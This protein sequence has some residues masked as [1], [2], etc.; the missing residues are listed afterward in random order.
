MSL[1]PFDSFQSRFVT[2]LLNFTRTCMDD[3]E[4]LLDED[5]EYECL[6]NDDDEALMQRSKRNCFEI[7]IAAKNERGWKFCRESFTTFAEV[8]E[9]HNSDSL[10]AD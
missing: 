1:S 7:A 8:K 9:S 2:Y 4:Y 6:L 10:V 3:S 5:K